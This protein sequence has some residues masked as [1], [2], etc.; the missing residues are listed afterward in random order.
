M[1]CWCAASLIS[2]SRFL[3]ALGYSS[4]VV[5]SMAVA[6]GSVTCIVMKDFGIVAS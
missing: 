1:V 2:S 4:L 6:K 5:A 3:L